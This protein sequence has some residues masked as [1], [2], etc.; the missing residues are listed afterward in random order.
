M[1]M[2]TTE[3]AKDLLDF[4]QILTVGFILKDM[5]KYSLLVR[6]L[7]ESDEFENINS[8][9]NDSKYEEHHKSA[10]IQASDNAKN[11][12]MYL[13]DNLGMQIGSV[14]EIE[15]GGTSTGYPNPFNTSTSFR[16]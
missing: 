6:K 12:A 5:N 14:L 13:A 11:K 10:L 4:I 8:S 7:S 1:K 2:I 15:E 9:W 3:Q 16:I